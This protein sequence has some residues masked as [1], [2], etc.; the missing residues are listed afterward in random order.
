MRSLVAC[1]ISLAVWLAVPSLAWAAQLSDVPSIPRPARLY[2]LADSSKSVVP[3]NVLGA[4][5]RLFARDAAG[6]HG[7]AFASVTLIR[8]PRDSALDAVTARKLAS[9]ANET[10]VDDLLH[11]LEGLRRTERQ[12]LPDTA[13]ASAQLGGAEARTSVALLSIRVDK[14]EKADLSVEAQVSLTVIDMRS[15]QK[16]SVSDFHTE[17]LDPGAEEVEEAARMLGLRYLDLPRDRS[18]SGSGVASAAPSERCVWGQKDAS[19]V[20]LGGALDLRF[21]VEDPVW[22]AP[23]S[24]PVTLVET[25]EGRPTTWVS[26]KRLRFEH[27]SSGAASAKAILEARTSIVARR[28]GVCTYQIETNHSRLR[29]AAGK[30]SVRIMPSAVFIELGIERILPK[31]EIEV[32]WFERNWVPFYAE[33]ATINPESDRMFRQLFVVN[34][35]DILA[36]GTVAR[37]AIT[38]THLPDVSE[39]LNRSML[40][41]IVTSMDA[42]GDLLGYRMLD[43]LTHSDFN[44]LSLV[45]NPFCGKLTDSL[46]VLLAKQD[47][48]ASLGDWQKNCSSAVRTFATNLK[49]KAEPVAWLGVRRGEESRTVYRAISAMRNHAEALV[50]TFREIFAPS[51]GE[52][53]RAREIYTIQPVGQHGRQGRPLRLTVNTEQRGPDVQILVRREFPHWSHGPYQELAL[54]VGP[55]LHLNLLSGGI[56]A[57]VSLRTYRYALKTGLDDMSFRSEIIVNPVGILAA[58]LDDPGAQSLAAGPQGVSIGLGYDSYRNSVFLLTA[59]EVSTSGPVFGISFGYFARFLWHY[60]G[61]DPSSFEI[62]PRFAL[63]WNVY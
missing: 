31:E 58:A 60:T 18:L 1:L 42:E 38:A 12:C 25:C 20:R 63:R 33:K 23:A 19:C 22:L 55:V 39:D 10:Q 32:T 4:L 57:E 34:G 8:E 9:G 21:E 52:A 44:P 40:H 6:K 41:V 29:L 47:V 17:K 28:V 7:L 37:A 62:G 30:A 56:A 24:L 14:A 49:S 50:P 43:S 13:M 48:R 5:C 59:N 15:K 51:Q 26:R 3:Q 45:R 46:R 2:L 11:L 54:S 36:Q 16:V 53:T 61:P 35:D 27:V